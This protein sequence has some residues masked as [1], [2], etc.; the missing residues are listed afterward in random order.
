M[1]RDEGL[2]CDV[3]FYAG[4][5]GRETPRAVRVGGREIPVE[6]VLGRRR[7]RDSSS[8]EVVE[9]FVCRLENRTVKLLV[10]DD[11]CRLVD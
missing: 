11:G 10:A 7:L 6:R 4:Y 3:L 9:E 5:R 1:I 2:S 8:G